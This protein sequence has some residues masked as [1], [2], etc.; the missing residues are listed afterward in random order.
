M[1]RKVL[2]VSLVLLV[3]LAS[4]MPAFASTEIDQQ[5]LNQGKLSDVVSSQASEDFLH[6]FAYAVTFDSAGGSLV[7][8]QLVIM[9]EKATEPAVPVRNGFTFAG[10]YYG[11]ALF[12]FAVTPITCDITLTARWS[13]TITDPILVSIDPSAKIEKQTGNKNNLKITIVGTYSDGS[14]KVLANTNYLISNNSADTYKV[15]VYNVYVATKGNDQIRECYIKW[16][17]IT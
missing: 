4:A 10:W 15:G 11:S 17:N 12:N 14:T 3:I 9:N 8:T 2:L 7:D 16:S 5:G 6:M 1:K 13:P